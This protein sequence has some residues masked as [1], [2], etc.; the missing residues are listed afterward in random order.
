MP[1][2]RETH[3]PTTPLTTA[4][5]YA[6]CTLANLAALATA[7]AL[8]QDARPRTAHRPN[9]PRRVIRRTATSSL[10]LAGTLLIVIM[11]RRVAG[12]CASPTPAPGDGTW[13]TPDDA[14]GTPTDLSGDTSDDDLPGPDNDSDPPPAEPPL[15]GITECLKDA[16]MKGV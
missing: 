13:R 8:A 1:G 11:T 15:D 9:A 16:I 3:E 14:D 2:S 6:A 12:T 5:A 7:L 10:A 4:R